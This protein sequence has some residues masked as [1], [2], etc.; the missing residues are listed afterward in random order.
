M[1]EALFS[2]IATFSSFP[3]HTNEHC[4]WANSLSVYHGNSNQNRVMQSLAYFW[5]EELENLNIVKQHST[6]SFNGHSMEM[7]EV[8]LVAMDESRSM[9]SSPKY[10]IKCKHQII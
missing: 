10:L 2:I 1:F 5:H 9:K 7:V 6:T 4:I 8:N 3:N